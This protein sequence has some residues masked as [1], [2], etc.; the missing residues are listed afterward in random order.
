MYC[1]LVALTLLSNAVSLSCD[2]PK[3]TQERVRW[4]DEILVNTQTV[5]SKYG[6]TTWI[7]Q[8]TLLGIV[9]D[10]RTMPWTWDVDM[11]TYSSNISTICRNTSRANIEL[12]GL[13]YH[14]Y[15]CFD[16]F[17]RVCKAKLNDSPIKYISNGE[18]VEARL[19]LYG[20]TRLSNGKYRAAFSKCQWDLDN[21]LYPLG[22]YVWN[23]GTYS[24]LGPRDY[25]YWLLM[26]YG[27]NWTIPDRYGR[28]V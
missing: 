26:S 13:G 24:I 8:S 28:C 17:A 14:I 22:R 5:L 27:V 1:Y 25:N 6:V 23:N 11:Q 4:M 2:F 9:R 12:R 16:N 3:T 10:K 19:D 20:V 7:V 21:H 15:H 18:P